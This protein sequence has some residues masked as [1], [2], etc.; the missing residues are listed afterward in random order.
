MKH[1]ECAALNSGNCIMLLIRIREKIFGMIPDKKRN[2][3][4]YDYTIFV[5]SY[6]TKMQI[7]NFHLK[8]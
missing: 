7:D 2:V 6:V 3:P 4:S 8:V 1:I 5:F